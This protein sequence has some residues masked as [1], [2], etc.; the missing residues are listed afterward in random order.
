[1]KRM[2][3]TL[4][5]SLVGFYF[6]WDAQGYHPLN[7][8]LLAV[9]IIWAGAIGYGIGSIFT[10]NRPVRRIAYW[11]ATFGLVGTLFAP[12][13]PFAASAARFGLGAL[14]GAF[15][16]AVFGALQASLGRRKRL[17]QGGK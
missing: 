10:E 7:L 12:A 15:A 14:A 8:W 11:V 9:P 1:M 2:L 16:G 17:A 6:G 4:G 13:I 5:M 3:W